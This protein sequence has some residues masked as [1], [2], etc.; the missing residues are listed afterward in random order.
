MSLAVTVAGC[1]RVAADRATVAV[2]SLMTGAL[3]LAAWEQWQEGFAARHWLLPLVAGLACA[4]WCGASLRRSR[5]SRGW[6]LEVAPDGRILVRDPIAGES[7]EAA[8]TM[9]WCL[10]RLIYLQARPMIKVAFAAPAADGRQSDPGAAAVGFPRPPAADCR[11]LLARR[12]PGD[13]DWHGLRR[14]LVWYRRSNRG[15]SD[16]A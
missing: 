14:W 13:P 12:Y 6:S 1:S 5:G 15:N 4:V 7:V 11:F 16:A 3:W 10:G 9:A 2:A 8:V